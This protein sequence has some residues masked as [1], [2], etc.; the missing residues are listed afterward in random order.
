M[1]SYK[2]IYKQKFSSGRYTIVPIRYEDRMDILKWRNEQIYHLRQDKPLTEKDQEIYF[3]TVVN[4]LFDQEQ[5]NQLLFSYLEDEKCIGYGGLVHINWID[6]NA[7]ISFIMNTDLE[8]DYFSKHWMMFLK[9]IEEIAFAE[10]HL[11]KISTYAFDLRPRLY[12]PIEDSGF[13]KE[14][15]LKRHCF[16]NTVFKDVII[17]TKFNTLDKL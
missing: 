13:V 4:N 1:N 11:N 9:L 6:K 17:H 5:P 15:T 10:L 7:E 8:K 2:A 14:A 12:K 3:K 16:F